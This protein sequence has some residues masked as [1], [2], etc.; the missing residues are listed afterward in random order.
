M[1]HPQASFSFIF[2]FPNIKIFTA[3]KCEICPSGIRCWDS[4][5]QP[6]GLES[7]PITTRPEFPPRN[8]SFLSTRFVSSLWALMLQRHTFIISVK[9]LHYFEMFVHGIGSWFYFCIIWIQKSLQL[10]TDPVSNIFVFSDYK[11]LTAL[12]SSWFSF[13]SSKRSP[14]S[15][16]REISPPTPSL[17]LLRMTIHHLKNNVKYFFHFSWSGPT[18]G[19][20]SPSA[21]RPLA[22]ALRCRR[23]WW[24]MATAHLVS[25]IRTHTFE[26]WWSVLS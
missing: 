1:G 25:H 6:S 4:N 21:E 8:I 9:Q 20:A 10:W 23:R 26:S 5:P 18:C 7:P 14:Y 22:A 17:M 12:D 24:S 15:N 3:N 13:L 2:V 16:F 19:R 11:K